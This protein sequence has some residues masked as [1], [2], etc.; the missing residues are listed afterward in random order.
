MRSCWS[1][2]RS[3]AFYTLRY[4]KEFASQG[5]LGDDSKSAP[6]M[7]QGGNSIYMI[8]FLPVLVAFSAGCKFGANPVLIITVVAILIH[9]N[10]IALIG[11]VEGIGAD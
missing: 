4:K 6:A 3:V 1:V 8:Y 5:N 11:A 7:P 9:P 2:I 10:F